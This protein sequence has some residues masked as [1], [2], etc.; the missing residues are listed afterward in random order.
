M[1]P[2]PEHPFS[3]AVSQFLALAD[4]GP[5]FSRHV[6][7]VPHHHAAQDF[8]GALRQALSH[9]VL[10]PPRL[11]TLPE[12]SRSVLPEQTPEPQSKRLGELHDFLARTG[13]LP[14]AGL[15]QASQE[16]SALLE[17]MDLA[18]TDLDGAAA[19]K[20]LAGQRGNAYL[21]MEAHIAQH[22]WQAMQQGRPSAAR[23]YARRLA[24]LAE[25]AGHPLYILGLSG[26][27]SLEEDFLAVW[28]RLQPVHI[29]PTPVPHTRRWQTLQTAWEHTE[30]PLQARARALARE[31][32]HSPLHQAF[33]IHAA[34]NLESAA[35]MAERVLLQWLADGRRRIGL[36]ALDRL[37]ARRLRALLERRRILVQDET[38][39]AFSTSAVS[40]VLERWLRLAGGRVW[41]R[42]L[43]DLLKSPFVFADADA[44]R[45]LAVH[46]LETVLRRHGA[47]TDLAGYQALLR[48]EG[49][50][51][52]LPLLQR[53]QTAQT[54]FAHAALPLTHWTRRLRAALGEMGALHALQAD[55]I[56]QQLLSLLHRLEQEAAD[57]PHA[58]TRNDWQRWLFLHLE[59]G[60]FAD[61]SVES[62]IRLTH[63]A[64]AH[65]RDL[66]GVLVL[67]AGAAHLPGGHAAGI[68]ND[69]TRRQLGLPTRADREDSSRAL[70]M[71][72]LCRVPQAVCVWQAEV[73]GSPAPLSP[74]LLHL[75]AF[76]Q[77]A[78]GQGLI[79]PLALGHARPGGNGQPMTSAP[80]ASRLPA[81]MSVSAWQSLVACPYQ[82]FARY[83]LGLNE[84]DEVPEEMDKSEYGSLV[85]RI[86]ARLHEKHPRLD[87]ASP[88]H[89]QA[90]LEELSAQVFTAAEK[91]QFQAL[92][93]HQRW[94]RHIPAYVAWALE[95]EAS[96]WHFQAA[97]VPLER[98]LDWGG[99]APVTLHGRADRLDQQAGTT[100]V[101]DYKTQAAQA[102]RS[103]LDASGE[104][105]QLAT[106]AWLSD[107]V[108]AGFVTLDEDRI[109]VLETGSA[110]DLA[111][112]A[113]RE[114]DRLQQTLAAMAAGQPLPAQGADKTCQWCEM[115]GLCRR[116][117]R[118]G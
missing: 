17:D 84:Q 55:A 12:L 50:K 25:Q 20:V 39:W 91:R 83:L 77:A 53:L 81:R 66:E 42:E 44:A 82:F 94:R 18:R 114:A 61:A 64:A 105:V 11:L 3:A 112:L 52:A 2:S 106:Y 45:S 75:E 23:L 89:W 80:R 28:A 4:G 73:D 59:Q 54:L 19:Q 117:H 107:A 7:L 62:P 35:R 8:R 34:H 79:Q 1:P 86:L 31:L 46:E 5:D 60:T 49:L 109:K 24:E 47:P 40:H 72:L 57:L 27:E 9:P 22:V 76:H 68:F 15:W 115:E 85:H 29:L 87:G 96:G 43:L 93:W 63:L 32:P 58:F 6:I 33:A 13:H 110:S 101:L 102:L 65:H 113:A 41:H 111:S 98:D 10:L 37:L 118:P 38:G 103:K 16:L 99:P 30:P 108:M 67:G 71:D 74:W 51:A 21:G 14:R 48:Q 95:H 69:A 70:F 97:E 100:A 92:A 26:L 36:V 90:I 116:A 56:G 88:E 104:D 78:W